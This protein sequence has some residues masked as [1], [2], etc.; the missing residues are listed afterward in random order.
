MVQVAVCSLDIPLPRLIYNASGM[1]FHCRL[2]DNVGG[3]D[4][5]QLVDPMDN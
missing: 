3:Y 5:P 2:D 1:Q 4:C